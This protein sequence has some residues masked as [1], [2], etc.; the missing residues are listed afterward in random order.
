MEGDISLSEMIAFFAGEGV[1]VIIECP[2]CHGYGSN[3]KETAD[4]CT[5]CGGSGLVR[6]EKTNQPERPTDQKGQDTNEKQH[7]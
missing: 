3:L 2:A 7:N 1:D 4:R 5:K 6:V